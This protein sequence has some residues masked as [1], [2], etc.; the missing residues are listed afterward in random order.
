MTDDQLLRYKLNWNYE[1]DTCTALHNTGYGWQVDVDAKGSLEG[2]PLAH[3]Y[4]LQQFHCHWGENTKCGSEHTVDG[5]VYSGEI[6]LVHWNA[7]LF[8]NFKEA[9]RCNG[10]LAVLG[11]FLQLGKEHS[12]LN[13]LTKLMP[14]IAYKADRIPITEKIDPA[15]FIPKNHTYWT[16]EGSLTTP[17]CYESVTWIVFR[18]PIEVS[19]EQLE[20]FRK[21]HRKPKSA[22]S[23]KPD[24]SP[25]CI[26]KNNRPTQTLHNRLIREAFQT[27]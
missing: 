27:N 6:H 21:L 1:S 17:P 13:K 15:A 24:T 4:R 19:E 2:G 22:D 12:E 8:E 16:Y 9:A 10:G 26:R 14:N 25:G 18:E 7:D 5:K 20:E 3:S 23:E 11:I